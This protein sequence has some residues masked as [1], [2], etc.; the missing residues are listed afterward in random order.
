MD[1]YAAFLSVMSVV[2][3]VSAVVLFV[4]S[5]VQVAR[6]RGRTAAAYLALT[7]LA[8]VVAAGFYFFRGLF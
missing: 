7:L 1:V 6:K 8:C 2:F 4:L 3:V 5:L